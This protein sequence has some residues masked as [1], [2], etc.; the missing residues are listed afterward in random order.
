VANTVYVTLTPATVGYTLTV[1]FLEGTTGTTTTLL[2]GV[3]FPYAPPTKLSVGIAGSTG[4]SD[5]NHEVR[6]FTILATTL[7]DHFAVTTPDTA[8][9]CQPAPVTI[10][11]ENTAQTAVATTVTVALST[12]TGHGDW[13]L[14]SGGGI[15]TA[16]PSNSG[17]ATY[18]YVASDF[19]VVG[20]TLRDTYPETVTI[21]AASG[22]ITASSGTALPSGDLPPTFVPSGFVITNGGNV[23]TTI[24]T[25]VAGLASNAGSTAQSL[26]LQAVR[27]DTKTGGCT[28]AFASG[29]AANISLAYQCNNPQSCI[30][31]QT[32]GVT[33]NGTTTAI[34]ANGASG[35][36]SYTSVPMKFSTANAEAPFSLTYSDVGQITLYAKY[37]IPLAGGAASPNTL[38]GSA[39]FVVQPAGFAL[40]NIHCALY[41]AGSCNT[42]L[43]SPGANPAAAAATGAWFEPAGA[44]FSATVTAQNAVGAASPNYGQEISPAGVTLT[45]TLVLPAGG[46]VPAVSNP[47]TFGA[48]SAGVATGSSFAWPEVGIITLTPSVAG[49]SYLGTGN[50]IGTT[51]G[52]IGRFV[53]SHFAVALNTPLFATGCSAGAFTYLGQPFV[54]S[55]PP[56]ITVTA[57]AQGGATTQNYTGSFFRLSNASLTGRTYSATPAS[58][59]LN[60]SGLPA[61]S[62]DPA[63]ASLGAGQ[64]T[65]TFNAG[66]GLSFT[67]T[68]PIAP[69]NANIA[70]SIDVIDLDGVAA[71]GNPV[72]FGASGGIGFTTTPSQWYG[73]LAARDALGS[74]WVDLPMSLTTQYY[75]GT[76]QGFTTN[77]G[78]SCTTA[79]ALAFSHYQLNLNSGETCVRDTGSPGR[80]GIGCAVAGSAGSTYSATAAGGGFNLT[81]AAPGAGDSGA[82]TVTATAPSWL[83]YPWI[84]AAFTGPSALATFGV[85][86]G[87]AARIYER[88]VY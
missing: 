66:T 32:L 37:N 24:G 39:Q 28:T 8:V 52:A 64:G 59:T 40:S 14:A 54:Y 45:P 1:Q 5:D 20:L 2:S 80:S 71:A 81:L 31:G 56:V 55:V 9:N 7:P 68:T 87:P 60:L 85:F 84:G 73:R 51:S 10:T 50:V 58:P 16:G 69:F 13:A 27:T 19:G 82:V 65:L 63:I 49:G 61:S 6:N 75:L 3:S 30:S 79:P 36:S 18:H 70:L 17:T 38:L 22:A 67:R 48:F 29:T 4:G 15:F 83:Q 21:G 43:G 47:A 12:S 11:A 34:A 62:M 23:I 57:Q 88:E 42:A 76:A 77:T 46:N 53:P 35:V 44:P 74:E 25:R 41:A 26:A 33:N 86:P 78:D 72:T